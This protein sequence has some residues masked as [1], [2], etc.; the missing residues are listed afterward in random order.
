[1]RRILLLL[2]LAVATGLGAGTASAQTLERLKAGE[3]LRIGIRVDA[4][5]FSYIQDE[6]PGGFTVQLCRAVAGEIGQDAGLDRLKVQYVTVDTT[7]RFQAV[8]DGRIDLLCGA[9]TATLKRRQLVDFSIPFFIDGASVLVRADGPEGFADLA[10]KRIGVR[11]STSTADRL[12]A[13]LTE[14][15]IDAQIVPVDVHDEG[16]SRLES[17]DI[18]A[19]FADRAILQ[20]L[21]LER[22]MPMAFQL[23]DQYFSYEPYALALPRGD[24][25]FRLAVDSALSRIY[26]SGAIDEIFD[27]TFG[28]A[29]R[30][31][32]LNALYVI[33]AL[34]E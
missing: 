20:F 8:A 10:G 32:L 5:P 30:S 2:A 23:S 25:D 14:V 22:G 28:N 31:E 12:A 34:P 6:K 9:S 1:M 24:S 13:T 29:Q 26:R 15:G 33:S 11:R 7:E 17:G 21:L 18:D 27:S 19:Y 16:I 3:P 4:L